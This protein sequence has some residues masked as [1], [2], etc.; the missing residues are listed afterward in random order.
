MTEARGNA[1]GWR[2][3][4]RARVYR[5]PREKTISLQRGALHQRHLSL[6]S[7]DSQTRATDQR[8]HL[9][10]HSLKNIPPSTPFDRQ[11]WAALRHRAGVGVALSHMPAASVQAVASHGHL[12]NMERGRWRARASIKTQTLPEYYQYSTPWLSTDRYT[13]RQDRGLATVY[14]ESSQMA[15][16]IADDLEYT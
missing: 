13:G 15:G 2:A 11:G 9:Q 12:P 6:C 4:E 10:P 14:L 8:L 3:Y 16:A 1:R 5:L 7:R